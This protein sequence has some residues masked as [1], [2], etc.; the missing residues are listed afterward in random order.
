MVLGFNSHGRYESL[1]GNHLHAKFSIWANCSRIVRFLM[2]S[3][4]R[5]FRKAKPSEISIMVMPSLE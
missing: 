4:Q 3:T 1:R 5:I 2:H